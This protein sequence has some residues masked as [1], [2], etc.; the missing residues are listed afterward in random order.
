[1]D[2]I[3]QQATAIHNANSIQ[4]QSVTSLR[5]ETTAETRGNK[6]TG[7]QNDYCAVNFNEQSKSLLKWFKSETQ[8][9]FIRLIY[10]KNLKSHEVI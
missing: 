7:V 5:R 10:I 2:L 1:V 8:I 9:T 3:S 6:I 4:Q